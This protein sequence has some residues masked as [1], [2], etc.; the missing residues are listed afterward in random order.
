MSSVESKYKVASDFEEASHD[1]N[2]NDNEDDGA[3]ATAPTREEAGAASDDDDDQADDKANEQKAEFEKMTPMQKR[4]FN[5]RLK[6]NEAR[7]ENLKEVLQEKKQKKKAADNED[8]S[9]SA[10][11]FFKHKKRV[12]EE[13]QSL[14]ITAE[15]S[16]QIER[17]QHK[18]AK[19]KAP[20][21]HEVFGQDNLYRAYVKRT[22]QIPNT[23]EEYEEMKEQLEGE[24]DE[25]LY[26]NVDSL[27]FGSSNSEQIPDKFLDRMTSELQQRADKRK[28][29]SRR[30]TF[31]E[32]EE[33]NYINQGNRIFNKSLSRSYDKYT[34]E[35]KQNLERGT[36][37]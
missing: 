11:P 26:R 19:N 31:H 2:D 4:L 36:A 18:K 1:N 14:E 20:V 13:N 22:K 21:G 10:K 30:R 5:L 6:M 3:I 25:Q 28:K 9:G 8:A 37:V 17:L 34:S 15:K 35:I 24:A 29:F 23:V 7:K 32:D 12:R 16:E 27:A 33:G